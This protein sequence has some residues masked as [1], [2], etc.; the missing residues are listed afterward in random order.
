MN[1]Q[2][3]IAYN[4]SAPA[5]LWRATIS[6]FVKLTPRYQLKNPVMFCV[7][8][9]SILTTLIY[10]QQLISP[11]THEAPWFIITTSIWLWFTVL[12]ANFAESIAEGRG[13]AQAEH[14]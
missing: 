2:P 13:K 1:A 14:L 7:Y 6:A 3:T 5:N 10:V 11:T 9:G 12:F 4:A 8:I